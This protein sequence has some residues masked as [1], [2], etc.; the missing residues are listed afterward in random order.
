MELKINKNKFEVFLEV[1][2]EIETVFKVVPVLYGSLGLARVVGEDGE[3]NDIDIFVPWKCLD[4]GWEEMLDMMAKLGFGLEDAKLR[5]FKRGKEI[6]S[7][8]KEEDLMELAKVNPNELRVA[9]VED[10]SFR[11]LR[12]EHYLNFYRYMLKNDH[13]QN[14]RGNADQDKISRIEAF[15]KNF[16]KKDGGQEV[17]A[18]ENEKMLEYLGGWKRCQADFENYR[19]MQQENNREL[20]NMATESLVLQLLPILDNFHASTDHIPED[21]KNGGWVTGI[22]HIQKQLET[23][24]KDNGVEEIEAKAGDQFNPELHEALHQ[25]EANGEKQETGAIVKVVSKGY[26]IGNKIIRAARVVVS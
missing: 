16:K 15:L 11:E 4:E 22:M 13:R 17:G 25:E 19:K 9:K 26:K 14:E 18:E 24:L 5:A 8:G 12:P 1:A 23:F 21:Q 20:M 7:F 10:V 2:K 3:A 6:V